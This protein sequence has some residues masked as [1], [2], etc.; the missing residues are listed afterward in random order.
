MTTA[1][2]TRQDPPA[3][4]DDVAALYERYAP[5]LY[6]Y[7][8]SLL[9]NPDAAADAAQQAW[10]RTLERTASPDADVRSFRAWLFT[11]ARNECFDVYSRGRRE[12]AAP[13]ADDTLGG[14][15]GADEVL[16]RREELRT[17]LADLGAVSERQ[18]RAIALR[19]VD[20]LPYG[21]V[22]GS[23]DTSVD[24]ARDLVC[25]ARQVLNERRRGRAESCEQIRLRI[26]RRRGAGHGLRAHLE[27]C[28]ACN[29]YELQVR[30]R[31]R[32]LAFSPIVLIRLCQG[33]LLSLW[34]RTTTAAG[35]LPAPRSAA[36][37]LAAA[38]AV[39]IPLT[40]HVIGA[41]HH[42]A[43][44]ATITAP[45]APRAVATHAAQ[46]R[47]NPAAGSYGERS[48]HTRANTE[49]GW[50]RG[51]GSAVRFGGAPPSASGAHTIALAT[52]TS[53]PA[54]GA[55][56]QRPVVALAR[57]TAQVVAGVVAG[58]RGAVRRLTES[59]L[60]AARAGSSEAAPIVDSGAVSQLVSSVASAGTALARTASPAK[61]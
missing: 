14:E 23:L 19:V 32:L 26:D 38:L 30:R 52:R 21:Q 18:R 3:T 41:H 39:G 53:S 27:Q 16:E 46:R 7:C 29:L 4:T 36:A 20:G 17:V 60:A 34:S 9:R 15:D 55:T 61:P 35:P 47:S 8:L 12:A 59:A 24:R 11:V 2:L 45:H 6:R 1:T 40:P 51:R 44:R 58:G 56:G 22:A 25:E 42:G 54:A 43:K 37:V 48:A 33:R 49:R 13:I 28:Q 57:R 10:L 50:G 31:T 5:S